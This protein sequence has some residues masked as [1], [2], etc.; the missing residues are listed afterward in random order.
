M[1]VAV[2]IS[3]LQM[4][5][6]RSS[7]GSFVSFQFQLRRHLIFQLEVI[8]E[9]EGDDELLWMIIAA[10]HAAAVVDVVVAIV[11]AA[12]VVVA[13][14]VA[15]VVAVADVVD[16]VAVIDVDNDDVIAFVL[17]VWF[18]LMFLML[19]LMFAAVHIFIDSSTIGNVDII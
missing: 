12:A 6:C 8:Q 17:K 7:Q 5:H 2:S 11:D 14:K 15:V 10:K 1:T 19:L 13:V 16:V 3:A 18:L 9:K 4:W